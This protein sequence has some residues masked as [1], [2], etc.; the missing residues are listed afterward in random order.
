MNNTHEIQI[1]GRVDSCYNEKWGTPRQGKYG[2]SSLATINLNTLVFTRDELQVLE[3]YSHAILIFIFNLNKTK[4]SQKK[5]RSYD[6][7][8]DKYFFCQNAK[9]TPPKIDNGEKRG[10]LATRSPHR[11]TP[12]GL[13]VCNIVKIDLYN[14]K[15]KVG[16][17]DIIDGT[18][19]IEILPY[20]HKYSVCTI[21]VSIPDWVNPKKNKDSVKLSVYFSLASFFDISTI[22]HEKREDSN[23]HFFEDGASSINFNKLLCFIAEILNIDPRSRYSKKKTSH[24]LFGIKLFNNFQL[25]YFHHEKCIKVIRFLRIDNLIVKGLNPRTVNWYSRLTNFII[26]ES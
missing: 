26:I 5:G 18:P 21:S 12:I 13:T 10:C 9:V 17:V 16:N 15:I 8:T 3:E 14:M 22:S 4:Y 23:I 19:I 20:T 24:K 2:S 1:V 7:F 11:P 25:I 6:T